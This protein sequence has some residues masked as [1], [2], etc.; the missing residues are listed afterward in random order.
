MKTQS[1]RRFI[2]A[3]A[4]TAILLPLASQL[5]VFS[6]SKKMKNRF[7][8]QVYFWLKNPGSEADKAMLIEGLGKLASVKSIKDYHLGVPAGSGREV[9]DG[10]YAISWLTIFKDKAAQDAYQ[11]DPIHLRFVEDYKHLWSKVIVY[12]SIDT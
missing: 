8:H 5:P 12:D 2:K 4:S 10:S 6:K 3:T 1:R 9:V 7:I 11:V